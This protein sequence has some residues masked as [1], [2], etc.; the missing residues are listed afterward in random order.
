MAAKDLLNFNQVA[1]LDHK[2]LK[3][4]SRCKFAKVQSGNNRD[5]RYFK[6]KISGHGPLNL[7]HVSVLQC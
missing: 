1:E 5:Q 3:V 2:E 7:G 4:R 6:V